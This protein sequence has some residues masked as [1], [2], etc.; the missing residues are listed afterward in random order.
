NSN[1]EP[2]TNVEAHNHLA[3]IIGNAPS[4][5]VGDADTLPAS[6]FLANSTPLSGYP[7]TVIVR[8]RDMQVI[9]DGSTGASGLP[10]VDVARDPEVDWANPPPPEVQSNCGGQD[11][12]YEPDNSPAEAGAIGPGEFEGGI[13]D[14]EP[15]FYNVEIDGPWRMTLNFSNALGDLDVY[16]WDAGADQPLRPDGRNVVG[17]DSTGDVETFE[18]QGRALVKVF[19]FRYASAPYTLSLEAL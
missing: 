2:A 17:S 10:M 14:A 3:R 5:R 13:C 9:A 6:G 8:R 15:D 1:Y 19:G 11:E 18:Y 4:V 7:T 16:V 12:I